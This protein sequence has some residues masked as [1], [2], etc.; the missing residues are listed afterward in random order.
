[1]GHRGRERERERERERLG[2]LFN[3]CL[4]VALSLSTP[5]PPAFISTLAFICIGSFATE[6]HLIRERISSWWRMRVIIAGIES[7]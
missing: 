2:Q 1:M 3:V 6:E 7:R 5:H 4:R